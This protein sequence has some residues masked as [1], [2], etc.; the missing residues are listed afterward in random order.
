MIK[1]K[2]IYQ[3][4]VDICALYHFVIRSAGVLCNGHVA[5]GC[6]S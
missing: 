5:A 3:S 4:I 6:K 1:R 2:R